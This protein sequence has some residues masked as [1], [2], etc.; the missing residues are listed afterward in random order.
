MNTITPKSILIIDAYNMIHRC[1]FNWGGGAADGD[2]QIVYNFIRLLKSTLS[3][4]PSDNVYFVLDGRPSHRLSMLPAYKANRARDTSNEEEVAY[5]DNFSV[6]KSSILDIVSSHIPVTTVYHPNSECDDIIYNLIKYKHSQDNVV[7]ISN[8]SDFIQLL[9]EEGEN[10][11]VW[12]PMKKSYRSHTDYDYVSWK[13]MVGD[14]SDN[15]SG[16]KGIGK[17][18][19]EKVLSTPGMLEEKLLDESFKSQYNSS[20]ELIK[21]LDFEDDWSEVEFVSP[22]FD[23]ESVKKSFELLKFSSLLKENYWDSFTKV[24]NLL[25]G[26]NK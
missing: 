2:N 23:S 14:R 15:I 9:S 26:E 1:R 16:V 10:I 5:W 7:V 6:Q 17:K 3:D 19:A 4:F 21:F 13:A 25:K 12:N 11:R 18:T 8:D 22:D 24:F 20:Y